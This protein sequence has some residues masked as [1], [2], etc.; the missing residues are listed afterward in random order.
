MWSLF[1]GYV[2]ELAGI[3]INFGGT[4]RT[5]EYVCLMQTAERQNPRII[6]MNR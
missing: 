2:Q 4:I 5:T 3:L 1:G 6:I